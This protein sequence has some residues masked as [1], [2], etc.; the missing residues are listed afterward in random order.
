ML[1]I[2]IAN[3]RVDLPADIQIALTIE[4]PMMLQD[5]VPTPYSLTFDLPPTARNLKI[6]NFPNRIASHKSSVVITR[7]C[8]IIFQSITIA[9]GVVSVNSYEQ[10]IK[11]VFKGA[12]LTETMRSQIYE[13]PM[14]TQVFPTSNWAAWDFDNPSNYAGRYR[15]MAIDAAKGLNP[16]MV[17]APIKTHTENTPLQFTYERQSRGELVT[18]SRYPQ[19]M[20]D[21]EYI[22]Y[23][24]PE[25]EEFALRSD[26]PAVRGEPF[27]IIHAPIFPFVRVNYILSS[28]FGA[29][30]DNN[31]FATT[32]LEDLV[33]PSTFFHNWKSN[34][35][36]R[37]QFNGPGGM[38][39]R[40]KP[41]FGS[42]PILPPGY[43][44]DPFFRLN[45]FLPAYPGP[46][47]LKELLKLFCASM[48]IKNGRFDLRL[49][50][51]IISEPVAHNWDSKLIGLPTITTE[52]KRVYKYGYE[53]EDQYIPD[54]DVV[55]VFSI[56]AMITDA[57]T[58]S[59]DPGEQ[60]TKVYNIS[61]IGAYYECIIDQTEDENGDPSDKYISFKLI[62]GGYGKTNDTSQETFDAVASLKPL[63]LEPKQYWVSAEN[64]KDT[65]P[66][67][68]WW[69]VP[70][71]DGDRTSRPEQAFIMF[72]RGM[73]DTPNFFVD[74]KYPLLSPYHLS[75]DNNVVGNLS[76]RWD[77][78][79]GL[80]ANFHAGFKNWI[81]R[82]RAKVSG[83]FLLSPIDLHN[84]DITSKVHLRGRNFYIE[85]IQV[86]IRHNRVD[87]AQIDLVEA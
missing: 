30:L 9:N 18:A 24:N 28:I 74:H 51:E 7:G 52:K 86:N 63:P 29:A 11:A 2:F 72:H 12:D 50:K 54:D 47:L 56:R 66:D 14:Y 79:E 38:M 58:E 57:D 27:A 85:R 5:R 1:E 65:H 48:V 45:D 60:M 76:L 44:T 41:P 20:M 80:L 31:V 77:G 49:N 62:D 69:T 33:V 8:K 32:E 46:D 55:S 83:S 21:T 37:V 42:N 53:G 10:S 39:F 68:Y 15:Q 19:R 13:M 36:D 64:D 67:L 16:R 82:D 22:N 71:F 59:L 3:Q 17:V 78:P 23:Y 73:V 81:E 70:Y 4:N 26:T 34:A 25:T 61:P 84:L 35:S 43:P 40:N 75:P 87:P 6:F